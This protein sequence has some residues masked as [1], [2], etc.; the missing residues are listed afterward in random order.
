[1]VRTSGSG[2]TIRCVADGDTEEPA[3]TGVV[4]MA[5]AQ[6]NSEPVPNLKLFDAINQC[7]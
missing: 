6:N 4:G 3:R 2:T 7:T 1:M 5:Q